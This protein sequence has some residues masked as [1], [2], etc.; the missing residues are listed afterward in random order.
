MTNF[1]V[2]LENLLALKNKQFRREYISC[3]LSRDFTHLSTKIEKE[4]HHFYTITNNIYPNQ[5]SLAPSLSHKLKMHQKCSSRTGFVTGQLFIKQLS[6]SIRLATLFNKW[7]NKIWI[8]CLNNKNE[9]EINTGKVFLL[10][11]KI[12]YYSLTFLKDTVIFLQN[13]LLICQF[14]SI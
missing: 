9:T 14:D 2:K 13:A 3:I 8:W 5:N 4:S 12:Q 11:T 6:K 1:W 10:P 7:R